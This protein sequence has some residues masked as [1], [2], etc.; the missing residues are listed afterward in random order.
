MT[1][2]FFLNL[3]QIIHTYHSVNKFQIFYDARF[4]KYRHE[5]LLSRHFEQINP[6]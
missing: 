6:G 1:V 2:L 5:H 4:S 3:Q